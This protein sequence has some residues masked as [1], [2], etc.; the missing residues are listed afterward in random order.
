M[1]IHH[2]YILI[3]LS[4][5]T[6]SKHPQ[7][8]L[9]ATCVQTIV[10]SS[11]SKASGKTPAKSAT[12]R[13]PGKSKAAAAALAD[14]DEKLDAHV[15]QKKDSDKSPPHHGSKEDE[16]AQNAIEM[17]RRALRAKMAMASPIRPPR[18]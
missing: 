5:H 16:D 6:Y 14:T 8:Y 12:V 7:A 10:P 18:R 1:H 11:A 9:C 17:R 4:R 13:T 15:L 3:N 2:I